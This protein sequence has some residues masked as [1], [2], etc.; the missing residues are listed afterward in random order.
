MYWPFCIS[1]NCFFIS[2]SKARLKVH[3]CKLR[4]KICVFFLCTL[5]Y[6][7]LQEETCQQWFKTMC[8]E[9]QRQLQLLLFTFSSLN[10]EIFVNFQ[11]VL[12]VLG[13][14]AVFRTAILRYYLYQH[15]FLQSCV[16]LLEY[17]LTGFFFTMA[18]QMAFLT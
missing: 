3:L 4:R 13:G 12:S 16:F 15:V 7:V 10:S 2:K 1:L 6:C 5:F 18:F 11:L 8:G 17:L 14:A 9:E